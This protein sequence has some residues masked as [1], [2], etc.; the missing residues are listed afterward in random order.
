MIYYIQSVWIFLCGG[1]MWAISRIVVESY[2][3]SV[4]VFIA[5]WVVSAW[6]GIALISLFEKNYRMAAK[7]QIKIE[8]ITL[9]Q[10]LFEEIVRQG[11][12][13]SE[14]SLEVEDPEEWHRF[15]SGT[16]EK[17]RKARKRFL[18]LSLAFAVAVVIYAKDFAW[19]MLLINKGW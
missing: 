19:L 8:N 14:I 17:Q 2:W 13:A 10:K 15:T 4:P 16:V 1:I 9:Y 11:D 5:L 6:I 3:I 18:S 12:K 7:H